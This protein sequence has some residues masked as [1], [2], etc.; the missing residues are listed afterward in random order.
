L[1]SWKL[2]LE[3]QFSAFQC[4]HYTFISSKLFFTFFFLSSSGPN[5]FFCSS[6]LSPLP[7]WAVYFSLEQHWL[8]V[9]LIHLL[10]ILTSLLLH[11]I[12]HF[13]YFCFLLMIISIVS[14]KYFKSFLCIAFFYYS[15]LLLI[16]S[17]YNLFISFFYLFNV[18]WYS[19]A[20]DFSLKIF[21]LLLN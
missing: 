5:H 1:K 4:S 10:C 20:F 21:Y 14:F 13:F 9:T 12:I 6:G 17:Y 15:Y 16:I 3:T 8:Q 18:L 19:F 7:L 11:L 2:C